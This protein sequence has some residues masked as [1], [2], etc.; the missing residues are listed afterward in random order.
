MLTGL[1][2]ADRRIGGTG[3]RDRDTLG[4]KTVEGTADP[5]NRLAGRTGNFMRADGTVEAFAEFASD[6][7]DA[8]LDGGKGSKVGSLPGRSGDAHTDG[9]PGVAVVTTSGHSCSV[10]LAAFQWPS[11][12]A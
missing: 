6:S 10:C 5:G 3:V 1:E 8:G 2:V 12:I 4:P 9:L 7:K 11:M